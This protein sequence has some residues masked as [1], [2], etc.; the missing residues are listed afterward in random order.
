MPILKPCLLFLLLLTAVCFRVNAQTGS[1]GDPVL[2][3]TFGVGTTYTPVGQPLP[4]SVT[5]LKFSGDKCP[6]QEGYYCIASSSGGCLGDTW[7]VVSFDNTRPSVPNG[8]MMVINASNNPD[9]FY[10]QRV[11]GSKMCPGAKYQF[12]VDIVNVLRKIPQTEGYVQP[13]ITFVVENASGQQLQAPIS[14]GIIPATTYLNWNN[15]PIDFIA[16]SDGSDV[17]VKL[18]NNSTGSLGNDL[19]ID[20]ITVRP[21]GPVIDAGFSTTTG[22]ISETQCID[23]GP[24]TYHL[25]TFVHNYDTPQYQWQVSLNDGV[26]T[27]LAGKTQADLDL[28]TEF[29]SPKAGKYQY[30]VG[31]LS[32]PGVSVNCQTFSAPLTVAVEKNPQYAMPAVTDVCEGEIISLIAD[33]GSDY[34]WTLPDGTTSTDHFLNV[35]TSAKPGD[36]GI[37]KVRIMDKGCATDKQT[38]VVVHP[39]LVV[40]VQDRSLTICEGASASLKA[41]GGTIYKW[42]PA[43]G[44]DHDDIASPLASPTITTEY[45]VVIG[46]GG[47]EK[48]RTVKVVV[49][50][51]IVADAGP[52]KAIQEGDAVKLNA[53][54][55][56]T[57]AAYYWTAADYL[58]DAQ[59]LT[60]IA[61]P[62]GD[63]TY[64]LHAIS[65]D[66]CGTVTD[67][68]FVKVYKKLTIPTAFTPNSDG[69]NDMWAIG[70][71]ETYPGVTVKIYTRSGQLVYQSTGYAKPWTGDYDGNLLPA[72]VYYYVIDKKNDTPFALQSGWVLL[73]R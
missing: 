73:V 42:T 57:T 7:H 47:C 17:V 46:N 2:N 69:V 53:T 8:Y 28:E 26:W 34:L 65:P 30:R 23:D 10:T 35:T 1:L 33:G 36:A 56:D 25:K 68:V 14:T 22:T 71:I 15:Y 18:R 40:G 27:N 32:A 43:L 62:T 44:L 66:N 16:P 58:D 48:E 12:A 19:I 37:Y 5:N 45:N 54:V 6:G 51:K 49:I 9:I 63:I 3:E 20:N 55:S 13:D 67:E 24:A 72:G 64:T 11:S 59:S 39:P 29:L 61:S 4:E 31:V 52:D 50:K 60:P 21:Y 41:T 38:Q 70:K